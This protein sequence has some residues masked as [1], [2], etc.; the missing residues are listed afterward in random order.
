ML[1]FQFESFSNKLV[2][3]YFAGDFSKDFKLVRAVCREVIK[4]RNPFFEFADPSNEKA[5]TIQADI[6]LAGKDYIAVHLYRLDSE[7]MRTDGIA[8]KH[9]QEQTN[10]D[11]VKNSQILLKKYYNGDLPL[12]TI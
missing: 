12:Q 10:I 6:N 4:Q 8:F 2:I 7:F 5:G 11:Q 9:I 3:K 1:S